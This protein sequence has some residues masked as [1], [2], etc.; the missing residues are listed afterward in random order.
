MRSS[1]NSS[2]HGSREATQ[3]VAVDGLVAEG[4]ELTTVARELVALRLD[5]L[6]RRLRGE[7]LVR[8]HALGAGDLLLE[9]VDLGLSVAGGPG[10]ARR[11]AS[12]MRC[13]SASSSTRTPLRA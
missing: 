2:G 9:P 4:I 13:S 1:P 8:E 11:F 5:H 10:L 3:S 12:K 6:G 7:P